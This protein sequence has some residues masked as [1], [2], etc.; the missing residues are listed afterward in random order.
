VEAIVLAGG[1]GTRLRQTVPNLPKP[2]AP[3]GEKPFLEILL[4]SLSN[5][6]FT[7]VIL[8]LGF[9]ANKI[10]EYF[11]GH[12]LGMELIYAIE[13]KPLGT[14][15]AIR[16][17]LSVCKYDHVFIFNGDTYLDLEVDEVEKIWRYIQHPIIVGCQVTDVSRYGQLIVE[18]GLVKGFSEKGAFGIGL[19]NAGCYVLPRNQL[20][21]IPLNHNFSIE[22]DYLKNIVTQLP[23]QVFITKGLFIDIGVSEDYLL[24]QQLLSDKQ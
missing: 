22:N 3:I 8:S 21:H 12:Y 6:G 20:D 19:I 5:K 14:G 2:M 1:F 4:A 15:G 24:A 13:D 10:S 23:I 17:A 18:E 9:M 7:R 11:G 16:K